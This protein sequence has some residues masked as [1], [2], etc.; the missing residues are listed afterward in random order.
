MLRAR[1]DIGDPMDGDTTQVH[2]PLQWNECA[3][4]HKIL[5]DV[6][7]WLHNHHP[8]WKEAMLH[9]LH[10]NEKGN[11]FTSLIPLERGKMRI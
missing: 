8:E 3:S 9:L 5:T 7:V 11:Y 4:T 10:I 2:P 6:Q 1:I